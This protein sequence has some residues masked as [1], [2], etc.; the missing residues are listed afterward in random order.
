M[1]RNVK[2]NWGKIFELLTPKQHA[3]YWMA[4]VQQAGSYDAILQ[5]MQGIPSDEKIVP[6][7]LKNV[8]AIA[9]NHQRHLPMKCRWHGVRSAMRDF[10]F[11]YHLMAGINE[12]IR[13]SLPTIQATASAIL[14]RLQLLLL[15][16]QYATTVETL[17]RGLEPTETQS[18]RATKSHRKPTPE[19]DDREVI[20]E[21]D[22]GPLAAV[23]R[24]AD[25]L[26]ELL[27]EVLIFRL[28]VRELSDK[29]LSRRDIL[30]PEWKRDLASTHHCLCTALA[31]CKTIV[32]TMRN[33]GAPPTGKEDPSQ[34]KPSTRLQEAHREAEEAYGAEQRSVE[35]Y[36]RMQAFHQVGNRTSQEPVEE[37]LEEL[38]Y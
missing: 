21:G 19:P 37:L 14:S 33:E 38:P 2:A 15:Q 29:W 27:V 25:G 13:Q 9:I 8:I 6:N 17:A 30:F 32:H 22:A 26:C 11:L 31:E 28:T 4:A 1:P 23:D 7:L 16:R 18:D 35:D 12:R 34:E 5:L 10:V 24:L 36:A 20:E 3:L